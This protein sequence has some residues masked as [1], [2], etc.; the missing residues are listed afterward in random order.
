MKEECMRETRRTIIVVALI[1]AMMVAALPLFARGQQE[2]GRMYIPVI[3]K[4]QQHQFWQTVKAG[5]DDA[6]R[7][8]G[9]DI[10]FEGPPSEADI[11]DQ[12]I[13]FQNAMAKAPSAVAL[14]A[15][16][17]NSV[18]D[19]LQEAVRRNIPIIG[20]DSGVPDAPEGSI[21]ANASTNNFAAAGLGAEKMFETLAGRIGA[22]LGGRYCAQRD[23]RA[24][25]PRVYRLGQPQEQQPGGDHRYGRPRLAPDNGCHRLGQ[26]DTGPCPGPEHPRHLLLQ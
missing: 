17:T 6:A 22:R 16:D 18:M 8:F 19:Q 7:E 1:V 10:T 15:L 20:F 26:R 23:P 11:Q 3:S 13:M 25:Q 14:A 12:V 2:A 24:G 5:A 21:Y 9:V 4:G